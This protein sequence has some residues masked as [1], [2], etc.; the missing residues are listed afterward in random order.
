MKQSRNL[1]NPGCGGLRSSVPLLFE[2][3]PSSSQAPWSVEKC[4]CIPDI[5]GSKRCPLYTPKVSCKAAV[6]VNTTSKPPHLKS[7]P[8]LPR[9]PATL[10]T[11]CPLMCSLIKNCTYGYEVGD[12][13]QVTRSLG[14]H[15]ADWSHAHVAFRCI[16][17]GQSR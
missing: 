7:M 17:W 15:S 12:E 8:P 6:T 16:S 3:H 9:L 4:P 13:A 1:K 10:A 5:P 2:S 11:Q 14:G